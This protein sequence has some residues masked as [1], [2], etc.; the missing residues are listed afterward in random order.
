ML[1]T[2]AVA[3]LV[4]S[5][6]TSPNESGVKSPDTNSPVESPSDYLPLK[7]EAS[8]DEDSGDLQPK[9]AKRRRK[10]DCKFKLYIFNL[11]FTA[12]DVVR[13]FEDS[14]EIPLIIEP[15]ETQT[16]QTSELASEQPKLEVPIIHLSPE[17]LELLKHEH[18][19]DSCETSPL[20]LSFTGIP[21]GTAIR[22]VGK[23]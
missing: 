22:A 8:N 17:D 3:E 19:K 23:L 9:P 1:S 20:P 7:R 12:K 5:S 10:P 11:F 6:S 2:F 4:A 21:Y 16:E 14:G 15:A 13:L 18:T